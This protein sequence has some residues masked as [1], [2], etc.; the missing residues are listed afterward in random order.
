MARDRI[1]RPVCLA[2]LV[3]AIVGLGP[4]AGLVAPAAIPV[5]DPGQVNP[6]PALESPRLEAP[7]DPRPQLVVVESRT[8]DWVKYIDLVIRVLA[9]VLAWLTA[10]KPPPEPTRT[11]VR[12]P[13]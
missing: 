5:A 4:I 3:L 9:L 2:A 13:V 8:A 7:A 6:A 11:P 1:R 10:P 12:Q